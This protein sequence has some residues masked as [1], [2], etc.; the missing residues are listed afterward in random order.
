MSVTLVGPGANP[1][2]GPETGGARRSGVARFR[3]A[4][5]SVRYVKYVDG[6]AVSGLQVVSADGKRAVI[7]NVY[8]RPEQRRRG[9]ADDLMAAARKD[10][11]SVEHAK[12]SSLSDDGKAW[13]RQRSS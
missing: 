9:H 8:T 6:V 13:G 3:S 10:F 2:I 1:M 12:E 5:G 4:Y 11:V 7:A